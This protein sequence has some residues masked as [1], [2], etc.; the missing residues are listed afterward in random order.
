MITVSDSYKKAVYAP[1]R[2]AYARVFM[3]MDGATT[4]YDREKIISIHIVEEMSVVSETVP[5]NELRLVMD[6]TEGDFS[7]LTLADSDKI[8]S[9]RIKF[10][11]EFGIELPDQ[12]V[13][14]IP[15]GTYY[16]VEWQNQTGSLTVSMTARDNFDMLSQTK[17][18]VPDTSETLYDLAVDILENAGITNYNIDTSL[19]DLSGMFT[20]DLDSRQAL[21]M[22]AIAAKSVVWQDRYGIIQIKP[23]DK[24]G[25][26]TEWFTYCGG[27][28]PLMYSSQSAFMLINDGY[29]IKNITYLNMYTE[30]KV[31]IEKQ[32]MDVTINGTKYVNPDVS[33]GKSLMLDNP[34]ISP[35][36]E[37]EIAEW[38]FAE[39]NKAYF[40]DCTWR[41]NPAIECGDVILA[42]D[43]FN[44]K[45]QTIVSKQEFEYAGYLRGKTE[46]KGGL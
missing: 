41:Q 16:L 2:T 39:S 13:E 10:D 44:S 35:E 38:I 18:T 4:L 12:S 32:V 22:I 23:L 11:V 43:S 6:N 40:Y 27:A 9:K 30:P 45:K 17:Y 36:R 26:S 1:I 3:T 42:Q 29:D 20:E 14:W 7:F 8:V 21:Q 25:I 28:F 19:S 31:K 24:I 33:N 46:S 15:M 37:A 5:S 34:L